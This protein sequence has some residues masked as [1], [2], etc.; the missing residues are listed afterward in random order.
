MRLNYI[1]P[2]FFTVRFKRSPKMWTIEQMHDLWNRSCLR[3]A[4]RQR[5]ISSYIKEIVREI[6]K[7][8]RGEHIV[9]FYS[10]DGSLHCYKFSYNSEFRSHAYS[11]DS[12]QFSK[13]KVSARNEKIEFILTNEKAFEMGQKFHQLKKLSTY[14]HD[15]VKQALWETINDK[16]RK[17]FKEKEIHPPSIFTINIGDSKY[18]V[19]TDDQH[20]YGY[21]V[22]HYGGVCIDDSINIK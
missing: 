4:K 5:D 15:R 18:Y 3:G 10:T 19:K 2:E 14:Q 11:I 16:L 17:H 22:F 7:N 20:R 1:N 6:P 9:Y 12:V 21:M 8:D 13:D